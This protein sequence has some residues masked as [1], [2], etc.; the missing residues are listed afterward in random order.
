[1]LRRRDFVRAAGAGLAGAALAGAGCRSDEGEPRGGGAAQAGPRNIVL[2]VIDTLRPDHLGCYGNELVRTP[3]IDALARESLR[4]TRVFPEAMPTVPARRSILTGRRVYPFRGWEPWQGLAKRAGW[5]PIMPGTPTLPT[6]L[7]DRGY[8]TAYVSDNPFLTHAEVFAPFRDTLDRYVRVMGQRGV[9]RPA[10]TVPRSEAVRRLPPVMRTEAGIRHVRQYLA[11]NGAGEVDE[12]QAAARVFT[13]SERLLGEAAGRKPF[14][15]VVDSFDPHEYWAPLRRDLEPYA[16]PDYRGADIADVRYTWSDYLTRAQLR[17][18]RATYA[19]SVTA[20]DRWLGHFLDGLRR[21]GLAQDTVVALV[22]DHGIYLGEHRLTGKSDSYLH[23]EL[24]QVPLLLRDPGGR[25]AGAASDYYA[26]TTDLAPTL[27]S[28]AGAPRSRRFEGAD[29][30]PLLDGKAPA[31]ERAFAYGGY[32]NFSFIRDERW[33]LV[34]RND[35]GW[36]LFYD[37][38]ED[39]GERRDVAKRHAK[40]ANAMWRRLLGEVERRPPRYSLEW[41]QRPSRELAG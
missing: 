8:W 13:E 26:T 37:L 9:V 28:M 14:F 12:E 38:E 24:I 21:R 34:V 6:I 17:H 4:F 3:N 1:V 30:S 23:P 22:S 29:L 2:I 36:R 15:M 11:N 31:E 35:N 10:D 5:S 32:G 7:R 40:A 20:V 33:A 16:D 27:T 25:A 39:P 41:T 19:A 18:L